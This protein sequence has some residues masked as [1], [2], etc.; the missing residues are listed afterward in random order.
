[1]HIDVQIVNAFI[2]GAVGGNPAGVVVDANALTAPQKLMV[3]QQVG[4]SE[5]AFVST[6]STATLKL[7]FFTPTRQIAHCGHATIATF[8]LLRQLGSIGEGLLSKETIDG[9][10]EILIEG[11]MAYMEQR[12]PKYTQIAAM[13]ELGERVVGSLGLTQT[14]LLSGIDPF[15][16]NTGNSFLLVPLP[17]ERSVAELRPN[18]DL[19]ESL[20]DELDLIGYY[21]F[22][23]EAKIKNRHAGARMFA[24]RFGIPEEAGTGMAAGPLA[25]FLYDYFRVN[26]RELLIEQGWLMHP[27]SPSVIKVVLELA[28]GKI[29][30]LMAGGAARTVSSMRVEL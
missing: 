20:S 1:M 14:Q 3:A 9:S 26:D 4:L 10:R 19:V 2:D 12:A 25:C 15:V 22:S 5:T 29:C 24:P 28:D 23:P 13:S 7:E 8:S 18:L 11:E 27:P 30:R 17:D 16:V 21:V 6:S